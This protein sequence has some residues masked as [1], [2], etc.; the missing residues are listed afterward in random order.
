[1]TNMPFVNVL[2]TQDDFINYTFQLLDIKNRLLLH[3]KTK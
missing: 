3:F 2:Q 1:M